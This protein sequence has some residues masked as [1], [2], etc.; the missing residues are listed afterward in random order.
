MEE[1]IIFLK[2]RMFQ[3]TDPRNDEIS[4]LSSIFTNAQF[5]NNLLHQHNVDF[6]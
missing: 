2:I 6:M 5:I 3:Y 1:P 4:Y